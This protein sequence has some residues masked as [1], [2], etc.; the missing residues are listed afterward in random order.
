MPKDNAPTT[1]TYKLIKM[2]AIA[3]N[4]VD[5][6]DIPCVYLWELKSDSCGFAVRIIN[7]PTDKYD[8]AITA[9]PYVVLEIDGVATTVYG[10]AYTASYNDA[11]TE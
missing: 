3:T 8:V 2:G 11:I 5:T 10:E 6:I 7:I 1:L 9:T 4:G